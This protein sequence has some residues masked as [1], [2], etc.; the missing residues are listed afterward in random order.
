MTEQHWFVA[1]KIL[2]FLEI[3][4]ETPIALSVVYYP[5]SPIIVHSILRIATQLKM[6]E[7]DLVLLEA[8]VAMKSKY[9]KY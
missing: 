1:E 5:T 6:Y 2:Q 9:L 3:F 8:I 4:D 7:N